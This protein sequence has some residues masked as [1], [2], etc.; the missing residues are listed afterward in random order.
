MPSFI[1]QPQQPP[2]LKVIPDESAGFKPV[3][4]EVAKQPAMDKPAP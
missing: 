4:V 3:K 1:H 2:V